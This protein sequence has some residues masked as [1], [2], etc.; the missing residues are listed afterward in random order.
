M[1]TDSPNLILVK[2]ITAVFVDRALPE[3]NGKLEQVID[4]SLKDLRLPADT[5][6]DG[7]EG[8]IARALRNT[9]DWLR[10]L[11]VNTKV[12]RVDLIERIRVNC[13]YNSEYVDSLDRLLVLEE[14]PYANAERVKGIVSELQFA[15]RNASFAKLFM[16]ANKKINFTQEITNIKDF[17]SGFSDDLR[18]FENA[19]DGEK[20]GFHGKLSTEDLGSVVE[21][22]RNTQE[23]R[24]H[25]GC[26]KT[27]LTGLNKMLGGFGYT[28]GELFNYGALT[29]NYKSGILLDHCRWFCTLN[30]PHL[31]DKNKKPMILRIS[32]ENRLEQDLPII[33]K[34]LWEAEHKKK[35]DIADIDVEEAAKYVVDRMSRMGYA[36]E[37]LCYDPNNIDIWDVLDIMNAYEAQGYE[38]AAVV[39]DYPEK[40]TK[41]K[42]GAGSN[43]RQ[44][45]VIVH[46]FEVLRNHCHPRG[47][48]QITAHQLSTKA[49][50]MAREGTSNFAQK[51]ATGSY[52]MNCNSLATILDGEC[53]LHIHKIGDE[54]FLTFARGKHRGGEETYMKHRNFAYKFE[55]F[56]GI[57]DDINEPESKALY[58]F[59]GIDGGQAEEGTSSFNGMKTEDDW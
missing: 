38:I 13:S 14:D 4:K 45:E 21:V 52:Y 25:E 15:L 18:T 8:E 43:Q 53:V 30:E 16:D 20:P 54:A 9:L 28:R 7:S 40:I 3:Q 47:I 55:E 24:S 19:E 51:V 27:G 46:T 6:G 11:P 56:G 10:T 41:K 1:I 26:L 32:F 42:K 58:S 2:A 44:D 12:G 22:M 57:V 39:I 35:I 48:T 37:I 36:F 59:A 17:V 23:L 31:L 5:L 29:H 33:Y 50:E 49:Q 34:S